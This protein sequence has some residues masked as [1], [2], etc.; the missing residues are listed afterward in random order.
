MSEAINILVLSD[1]K[2][3]HENQSL[4]LAEAMARQVPAEIRT[5]RLDT[6][7]NIISRVR[8]ALGG[9][10]RCADTD[11]VIAAG[12]ATHLPLLAAARARAA[13]SIV[14]MKPGLPMRLFDWVIAPE[15]DFPGA[16]SGGNLILSKGALNR[17][18]PGEGEKSGKLLLIGGP[19]KTHGCDEKELIGQIG[20][21]AS[22][23]AWQVADSRRT[24]AGFLDKLQDEVPGLEVFPHERTEPGWLARKLANVEEVW[25][26]EDSVSMVYEALTAGARVG[27]LDMPRLKSDARVVRG[28]EQLKAEGYFI[29]KGQEPR[30]NL[31]EADRCAMILLKM[32]EGTP[33]RKFL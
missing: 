27:V 3:G 22:G 33:N 12:H 15:H 32:C 29:N 31:A 17:V 9:K 6:G 30:G 2:A 25:V 28:L 8:L 20:R 14:L 4:G 19:S 1:G 18:V 16:A 5:L 13:K 26:T 23:G 24:P 10:G 11:F 21:I 7:K